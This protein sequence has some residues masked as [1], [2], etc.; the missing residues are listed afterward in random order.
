MD[1]GWDG[2][3]YFKNKYK[4]DT[5]TKGILH[6]IFTDGERCTQARGHIWAR[7]VNRLISIEYL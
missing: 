1:E 6:Q 5:E 7:L 2:G 4:T 3:L